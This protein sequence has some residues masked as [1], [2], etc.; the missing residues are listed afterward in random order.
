MSF[1]ALLGNVKEQ[2]GCM[3]VQSKC[4]F[5][6]HELIRVVMLF[7]AGQ[8]CRVQRV[9][10]VQKVCKIACCCHMATQNNE[11][12]AGKCAV[13]CLVEMAGLYSR[14]GCGCVVLG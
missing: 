3:K 1:V 14:F 8:R 11:R 2:E 12:G 4:L 9:N 7:R 6:A 10:D 5:G 13:K